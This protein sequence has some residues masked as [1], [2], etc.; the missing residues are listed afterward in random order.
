MGEA[1]DQI[2]D[3]AGPAAAS[4]SRSSSTMRTMAGSSAAIRVGAKAR[5]TSWR[6]RRV[7]L[8]VDGEHVPCERRAGKAFVDDVR[9]L[10]EGGEEVL[11]EPGVAERL[12]S[13]VVTDHQ[14]GLVPAGQLHLVHRALRSH[15]CEQAGT[16]RS[17]S[18]CPRHPRSRGS[19]TSPCSLQK[20]EHTSDR[21]WMRP[22][23]PASA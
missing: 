20:P 5:A 11:R 4:S 10:V 22:F 19:Q 3:G 12:A 16:G 7:V 18:R 23:G 15:V 17:V 13:G 8:P 21:C 14:P 2:D 6:K 9:V 1:L